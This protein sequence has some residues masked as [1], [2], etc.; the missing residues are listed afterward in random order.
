MDF[1]AQC[2]QR[3]S[4]LLGRNGQEH[5]LCLEVIKR[6]LRRC[7]AHTGCVAEQ[8]K[9]R[10]AQRELVLRETRTKISVLGARHEICVSEAQLNIKAVAILRQ[11]S[12]TDQFGIKQL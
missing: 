5:K 6:G 2:V 7:N 1:H 8:L 11:H 3:R 4:R 9:K 12:V 10:C